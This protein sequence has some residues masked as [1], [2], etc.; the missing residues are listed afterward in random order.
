MKLF[1][2]VIIGVVLTALNLTTAQAEDSKNCPQEFN[3]EMRQ[4]H[5]KK[6]LNLCDFFK[7]SAPVLIVNTASHCGYTKQFKQLEA[8]YQQH[9][10][11]G[12]VILGF[13]SNSFNQEEKSEEGT[14]RVCYK[15]YGVTF[16]MFE[17]VDVKGKTAHPIFRYLAAS[18]QEPQWNFNKY[19]VVN[20]KVEH[21][22]SSVKPTD[23]KIEGKIQQA[24]GAPTK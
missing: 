16:P 8:L 1:A 24:L 19:L 4:L 2:T 10:E 17:H 18:S 3:V 11:Q 6:T 5:S 12:F 7:T 23:T 13:P 21:F 9:K 15:N 14:A 20:G 22:E